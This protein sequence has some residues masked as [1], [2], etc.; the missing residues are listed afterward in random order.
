MLSDSEAVIFC[1]REDYIV[2]IISAEQAEQG[3][4]RCA[5]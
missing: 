3:S 2:N 1:D 5:R 4:R